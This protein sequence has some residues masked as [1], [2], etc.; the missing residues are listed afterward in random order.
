MSV[1]LSHGGLTVYTGSATSQELL[2]G[3][4]EGVAVL[5]HDGS[6][7]WEVAHRALE[8]HHI[9]ALTFEP[10]SGTWFAGAYRTGIFASVDNG[11]PW[12][13]RTTGSDV[14]SVSS[15]ATVALPSGVRVYA[16][17]EPAHLYFSDDLGAHW[18]ELPALLTAPSLP[19]WR[20][21][22]EPFAAHT[23]HISFAPGN[24]VTLYVSVEVGGLHK[25]TDGGQTFRELTVPHLDAHRTIVHPHNPERVYLS[26]G[27][28][29]Y[30]SPDGGETWE[31]LLSKGNHIG[32]YPDLMVYLPSNPDTMFLCASR[33]GPRSWI[34]EHEVAGG[35]I[36][37]SDD[38]GR[39]WQS[40]MNGIP[41]RFH[42]SIE[43]FVLE[44]AAGVV[45][46]FAATTDGEVVWSSDEGR[47]WR[48]IAHLAPVSK[49]VHAEM[50]Q[51]GGATPLKFPDG[52]MII[53]GKRIPAPA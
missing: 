41:D 27:I 2:V 10:V 52:S 44:E 13:L 38:G 6:G 45:S 9:H 18:S 15:V 36:A 8:D 53:N 50:M 20:F 23:K 34:E 28:G 14:T 16:G 47:N 35:Q 21:A 51:G 19:K 5:R 24:P 11:R 25:S 29:V 7:N 48:S 3:T 46:L 43:A 40:C 39:T 42:G 22:A 32:E 33:K 31:Q 1:S 49:S 26:G 12:E 30:E 4:V 37:R 17:T